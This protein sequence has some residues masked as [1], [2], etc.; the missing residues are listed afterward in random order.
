MAENITRCP[1]CH[2]SFRITDAHLKTAKG[3][4]RCGSCLTIFN[5]LDHLTIAP[6]KTSP[7]FQKKI[8]QEDQAE[9]ICDDMNLKSNDGDVNYSD[10]FNQ[11]VLSSSKNND[12]FS[13]FEREAAQEEKPE[14]ESQDDSWALKLLEE[15]END[16]P[17][18]SDAQIEPQT[19][20]SYADTDPFA[21][22]IESLESDNEEDLHE[23]E[24]D[25]EEFYHADKFKIVEDEPEE[26]NEE[27]EYS[28]PDFTSQSSNSVSGGLSAQFLD[29]IEPEPVEFAWVTSNPI[30]HS[31]LLWGSLSLLAG[32]L[33]AVQ[34]A[35]IKFDDWSQKEAYRGYYQQACNLLGCSLPQ[36][37]D[38]NAIS[39][40]NLIVRS[41][42]T[43]ENA[44]VV[45]FILQNGAFFEQPFPG[46]GL[47]FTDHQNQQVA[48]RCFQPDEYLGGEL[49]GKKNMPVKQPIHIAIDIADP[50]E[51][52]TGY[53]I[54]IC[55]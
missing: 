20:E 27:I 35:W 23:P 40:R 14:D 24:I 37:V 39:A 48:Y 15:D 29:S 53:K 55:Q 12:D 26:Q 32:L 46:I 4:V 52:A 1:K 49:T 36:L 44:L 51:I 25:Y 47:T 16:E 7:N 13:L 50:G 6:T 45:D 17:D 30:W 19:E 33:L 9:L 2:T 54:N 43:T 41:N 42:T 5:A 34:V 38:F 8:S 18:F 10:E 21:A 3:S 11:E 22:A 28:G 31:K